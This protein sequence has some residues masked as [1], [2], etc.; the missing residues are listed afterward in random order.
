MSACLMCGE[1]LPPGGAGRPA[2][3]CSTRCRV[4]HHRRELRY[5]QLTKVCNETPRLDG[6]LVLELFPGAG[7]LG[8]DRRTW[9]GGVR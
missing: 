3:F 1:N 4:A 8:S 9:G 6:V 7:L 2:Q 5:T